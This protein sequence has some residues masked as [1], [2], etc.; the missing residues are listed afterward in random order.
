MIKAPPAPNLEVMAESIKR[1]Y[2]EKLRD[3]F[4]GKAMQCL[5]ASETKSTPKEFAKA[6]YLMADEMLKARSA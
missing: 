1:E 3:E 2:L 4:A 5:L 6:S